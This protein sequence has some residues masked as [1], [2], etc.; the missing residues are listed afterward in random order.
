VN[1][2]AR[3]QTNRGPDGLFSAAKWAPLPSGL[4]GPATLTPLKPKTF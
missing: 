4:A 2:P 1:F 3:L